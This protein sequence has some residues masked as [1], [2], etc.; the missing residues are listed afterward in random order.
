MKKYSILI[1]ER[2]ESQ[3]DRTTER[4]KDRQNTRQED[5]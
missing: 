2:K 1:N 4:Q 5:E 3:K